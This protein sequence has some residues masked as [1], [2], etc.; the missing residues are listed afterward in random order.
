MDVERIIEDLIAGAERAGGRVERQSGAGREE[1]LA[2]YPSAGNRHRH[3]LASAFEAGLETA[4]RQHKVAFLG[5]VAP[6]L[7]SVAGPAIARAGLGRLAPMAAKA[8]GSGVKGQIF[9]AAASTLGG[10]AGQHLGAPGN[11]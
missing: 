6:L 1:K 11:A 3:G 10:M 9:D 2:S 8:L 5:A 7:G 4:L